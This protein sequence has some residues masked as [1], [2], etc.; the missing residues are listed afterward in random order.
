MS[1]SAPDV[2][3][4]RPL[5]ETGADGKTLKFIGD[6]LT[7]SARQTTAV[8]DRVL[9]NYE[10]D[11]ATWAARYLRAIQALESI[12]RTTSPHER[13]TDLFDR[14]NDLLADQGYYPS[15]ASDVL[16]RYEERKLM[17]EAEDAKAKAETEAGQ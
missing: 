16:E 6:V 10:E 12:A 17:R 3:R 2:E 11:R 4:P 1:A 13:D 9:D 7:A 15:S 8:Y 5:T 14:I